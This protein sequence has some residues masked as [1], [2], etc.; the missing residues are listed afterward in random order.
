MHLCPT[1]LGEKFGHVERVATRL[2][3]D[4]EDLA[5]TMEDFSSAMIKWASHEPHLAQPL[6]KFGMC[7]EANG[8]AIKTLVCMLERKVESVCF[9]IFVCL[10]QNEANA[11]SMLMATK[12][13]QLY[14][15]A[16]VVSEVTAFL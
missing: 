15:A 6:Q 11:Y 16:G 8:K 5:N 1:E 2:H 7:V 12:E 14:C 10:F 4:R 3:T 13:Y 9:R